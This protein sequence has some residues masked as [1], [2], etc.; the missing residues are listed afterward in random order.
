MELERTL[1]IIKPD[2]V[3][4]GLVGEIIKHYEDQRFKILALKMVSLTKKQAEDFYAVHKGKP[5]YDG[6]TTFMSS[7]PCVAL[8]LAGEEVIARNRDLMGATDPAKAGGGTIRQK[9]GTNIERNVV[10]G[11]DSL[12]T[13]AFELPFF[14]N[15]LELSI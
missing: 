15:S 10:H 11:S 8:A 7:G 3:A 1:A 4:K 12:E 9:Y 13:A 14:F 2:A 5:F 6:L